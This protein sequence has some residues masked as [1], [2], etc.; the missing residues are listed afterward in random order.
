MVKLRYTPFFFIF[1]FS[2]LHCAKLASQNSVQSMMT[3]GGLRPGYVGDKACIRCHQTE[4]LSYLHTSH[5][6]TSQW[7]DKA[8]VLGNFLNG[9]N[10]LIIHDPAAKN[11]EPGLY[12]KM[13]QK[14][15]RYYE[16]AVTGWAP[17][18]ERRSEPI[19]IVIGSGVR[20]LTY[21][22]WDEDRLYE[23][24]VSYW[25]AGHR[26]INSPG[27]EDGTANFSRPV[28]PRCMECHAAYLQP[29]FSDPLMNAYNK[30]SFVPGIACET[31]HG[32]GQK[33]LSKQT[34]GLGAKG[35]GTIL[36]PAEFPRERQMDLCALCHNGVQ[37]EEIAPAF[38]YV[39]GE[40]LSQYFRPLPA[41]SEEHPDVHGDQIGLLEKSRC[42]RE[43]KT[44]T[45][46]TCHDVHAAEKTAA[47]YSQRCLQCHAW[48]S[49]GK[50]KVLG[51]KIRQN[52][53]TCHMP[54]EPT[55]VIVSKTAGK[56]IRAMMRNHWIKI[57]PEIHIQSY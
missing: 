47:F 22:Y 32:P 26:W 43:S 15:G 30:D 2:L 23:L 4:G 3:Q 42:Y 35:D 41:S 51:A 19:D 7:A 21:L 28:T 53:T 56:E 13:E 27:Y 45:C 10:I 1:C 34:A 50:A 38:S 5:H 52:C 49:C 18:L 29:L 36:N 33:H 31:C 48:Q 16:T 46:S 12:F 54:V 20:G 40:P 6:L 17:D 39:P 14:D 25:K 57:Y 9:S 8:S 55:Q 44:M 37:R 24:P 11:G